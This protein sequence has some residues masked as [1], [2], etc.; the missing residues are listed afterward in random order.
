MHQHENTV[1]YRLNIVKKA[2]KMEDNKIFFL[3]ILA[4][5]TQIGMLLGEQ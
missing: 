5:A 4:I 2:L 3:E 1:R